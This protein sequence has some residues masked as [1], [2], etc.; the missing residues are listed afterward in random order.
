M[1]NILQQSILF[2]VDYCK[3]IYKDPKSNDSVIVL[4]RDKYQIIFEN[5]SGT[6]QVNRGKVHKYLGMTLD[7]TTVGKVKITML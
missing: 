7:Y 5:G 1:V 6:M 4:L 2:H 3:F